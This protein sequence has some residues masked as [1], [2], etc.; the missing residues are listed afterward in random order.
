MKF[1]LILLVSDIPDKDG[2]VYGKETLKAM[3]LQNE[4][5]FYEEYKSSD[6]KVVGRLVSKKEIEVDDKEYWAR[7]THLN[8]PLFITDQIT[9]K[10]EIL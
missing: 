1:Q 7:L 9:G 10:T 5:L 4:D 3:A 8:T 2:K 6:G